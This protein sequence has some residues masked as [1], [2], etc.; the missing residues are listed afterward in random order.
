[1]SSIK[2]EE[3][4]K[5]E[6]LENVTILHMLCLFIMLFALVISR[7]LFAEHIFP[8]INYEAILYLAL[9]LISFGLVNLYSLSVTHE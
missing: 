5:R 7:N 1:M 6:L 3:K 2:H 9:C 4:R 8:F